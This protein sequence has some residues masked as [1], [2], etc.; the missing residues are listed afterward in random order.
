MYVVDLLRIKSEDLGSTCED[1]VSGNDGTMR[2][3]I[4]RSW[5]S[6]EYVRKIAWTTLYLF[7]LNLF[8]SYLNQALHYPLRPLSCLSLVYACV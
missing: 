7:F 1:I 8:F 5:K 6:E 4:P 2:R 3:R